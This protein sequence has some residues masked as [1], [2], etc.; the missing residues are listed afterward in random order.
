MASTQQNSNST[1]SISIT[2][3]S[4]KKPFIGL[5]DL[6]FGL[7]AITNGEMGLDIDAG[8]T[9]I[10]LSYDND[11]SA[12]V[13][14]HYDNAHDKFDNF[15]NYLHFRRNNVYARSRPF[16]P[17][18][19]SESDYGYLLGT[20]VGG[21]FADVGYTNAKYYYQDYLDNK[22]PD[23]KSNGMF[24]GWEWNIIWRSEH[25]WGATFGFGSKRYRVKLPNATESK[26]KIRTNSLGVTY[27]LIWD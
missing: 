25:R 11:A 24:W 10:N 15:V 23:Y 26:Y 14:V 12:T 22:G 9:I 4:K 1:K 5:Y 2:E 16:T 17:S 19:S 20:L 3:Q 21:L 7:G 13:E 8:A 18:P 27:N 6:Q